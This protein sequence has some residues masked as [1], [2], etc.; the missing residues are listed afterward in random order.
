MG[1]GLVAIG[2]E[3]MGDG[4]LEVPT[5]MTDVTTYFKVLSSKR[6]LR[7]R[8]VELSDE[9]ALLP[10][11]RAVTGFATLLELSAMGIVVARGTAVEL[12]SHIFRYGVGACCVTLLTG[13]LAMQAGQ[14]ELGFGMIKATRV[15]PGL[16]VMALHTVRPKLP[17]VFVFMAGNA[18]AGK[19][20][21]SPVG[22]LHLQGCALQVAD[23]GGVVAFG[24]GEA[25]V[26][27][28][29]RKARLRVVEFCRRRI[30]V[31]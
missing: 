8:M 24:A 25:R 16:I 31:Q 18:A 12:E 14:R 3:I 17:L 1:I 20:Q 23:V 2:A 27:A 9:R 6:V 22:V 30:P 10:G 11:R 13:D 28:V 7:L 29:E 15:F 26:F 21:I 4:S 5:A 19:A